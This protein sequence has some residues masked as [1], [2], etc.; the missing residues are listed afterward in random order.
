MKMHCKYSILVK[1][2]SNFP[3]ATIYIW[4]IL[5][6]LSDLFLI[7]RVYRNNVP[8]RLLGTRFT[9]AILAFNSDRVEAELKP[10]IL[11]PGPNVLTA[12]QKV[13]QSD[14]KGFLGAPVSSYTTI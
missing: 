3:K 6:K 7:Y 8:V 9:N 2:L 11:D 10:G 5:T 14:D 13:R 12:L 4:L 1:N